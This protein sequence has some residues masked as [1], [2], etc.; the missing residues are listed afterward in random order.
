MTQNNL[1]IG[2]QTV[3]EVLQQYSTV[4]AKAAS[5]NVAK[6]PY[7]LA[8]G[9]QEL[10]ADALCEANVAVVNGF[11]LYNPAL[12]S[13]ETFINTKVY[14]HFK[15][16]QRQNAHHSEMEVARSTLEKRCVDET[17]GEG[18]YS[19][20]YLDY[21]EAEDEWECLERQRE[22]ESAVKAMMR[23]AQPGRQTLCLQRYLVAL[24]E[25]ES[26]PVPY[27]AK[28]LGCSRQQVYNILK[29][30]VAQLPS[31]LADEIRDLL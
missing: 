5:R 17:T 14:W 22:L 18:G 31:D 28:A 29:D 19:S 16:L 9:W 12:S 7:D 20:D 13:L 21:D 24:K 8:L 30:V 11:H 2:T 6:V 27:V 10:Q 25:K 1:N 23:F 3:A 15:E 26:Q 4:I